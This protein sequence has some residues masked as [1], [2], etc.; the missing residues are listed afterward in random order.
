MT[1]YVRVFETSDYDEANEYINKGW[2]LI[3]APTKTRFDGESGYSSYT[4]YTLGLSSKEY[5]NGLLAIIREYEKYGLK[6]TLLEKVSREMDD[7]IEEYD[8]VGFWNSDSPLANYMSNYEDV[9]NNE[10]VKYFKD[11]KQNDDDIPF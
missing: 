2:D 11:K 1:N 10:K 3:D 7:N 5:A 8:T 6:E 9:V 4:K